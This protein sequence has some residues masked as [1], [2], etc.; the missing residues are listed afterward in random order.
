MS[1]KRKIILGV[2]AVALISIGVLSYIFFSGDDN[3]RVFQK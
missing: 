3:K 2:V 1:K